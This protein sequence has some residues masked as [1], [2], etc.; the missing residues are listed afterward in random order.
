MSLSIKTVAEEVPLWVSY[1]FLGAVLYQTFHWVEH[2]AQVYQH[3]WLGIPILEAHGILFFFD[4]EW[5]HFVF[6]TLYWIG[7]FVVFWGASM[8]KRNSPTRN[9]PVVFWGFIV[10]GLI[11]QSWHQVEH[12][13]KIWQHIVRSC[14]PCPGILAYYIDGIYLHFTYNTVVLIFP[15]IAF[16]G[17]AFFRRLMTKV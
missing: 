16:F 12:F 7:L 15:L 9:K 1:V 14:E 13:V 4:L 17:Y 5:N 3:W 10:G 2:L 8:Y 11:V 6:N